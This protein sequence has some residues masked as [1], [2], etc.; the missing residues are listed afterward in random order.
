MR[1]ALPLRKDRIPLVRQ[2]FHRH[3]HD[4]YRVLRRIYQR[5]GGDPDRIAV[6]RDLTHDLTISRGEAMRILAFLARERYISLRDAGLRVRISRKGVGYIEG[7]RG[8][9]ETV[10]GALAPVA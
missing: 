9:R 1:P 10:R 4:R 2:G 6:G 8:K 5:C 3:E 7:G